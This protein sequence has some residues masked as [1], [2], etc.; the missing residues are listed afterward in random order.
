MAKMKTNQGTMMKDTVIYMIAKCTEAVVGVLTMS[1]MTFLFAAE[2]MGKYSTI[3]IAITTIGMVAIQW[4]AQATVRYVNKYDVENRRDEF[5]STVFYAWFKANVVVIGISVVCA[6]LFT[7]VTGDNLARDWGWIFVIGLCWFV[8][9]NTSQVVTSITAALRHS[10]LNLLLSVITVVGKLG[11]IVFFCRVFGSRI[12]WIFLS[13]FLVDALTSAIGIIRLKLYKYIQFKNYSKDILKELSVYGTPL[14]GNMITTSVLNKS[15]IYIVTAFL[16]ASAAGIYQT[17]YSL[18]ATA[19]TMLASAIMRGSYPTVLRVWSEGDKK[20]AT[21]LVS[22]TARL[23]LML[24]IPGVAG[25]GILSDVIAR[26]LY[27]PEYFTGHDIMFW[28]A[29]GMMFLGLTEYNIKPWELN[30]KA[31]CIFS[32]SLIGGI[33]NVGLNLILV[34]VVGYKVAAFTTFA[35]F[36]VYFILA[37][38]GTRK[39]DQWSLPLKVYVRIVGS[40]LGMAVVLMFVKKVLPYNVITLVLMVGIG[41]VVYGICLILSGEVKEEVKKILSVIDSKRRRK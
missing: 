20:L 33:V 1:V 13:Y 5:F 9:N 30:A 39:Y 8:T 38:V 37:R 36:F 34:P 19:F 25:V 11:F 18:V 40:A 12:E 41:V 35:G 6:L 22:S 23:Y 24:A 31:T 28:V 26:A 17:N 27:A 29:L 2:Q 3:N 21:Q 4:L 15:D 14:M 16:G 10:A 7:F 32:R